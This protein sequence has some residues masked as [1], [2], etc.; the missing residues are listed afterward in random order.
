MVRDW[1]KDICKHTI[2]SSA[3]LLAIAGS[4]RAQEVRQAPAPN[5]SVDL[6]ARIEA[7][8]REID[9]LKRM[10]Q[11]GGVQRTASGAIA[12]DKMD[13]SAVKKIIDGYL[14]EKEQKKKADEA[15]AAK[16]LEDEGF[17]V[18]SDLKMSARW[19]PYQ[20]LILETPNKDFT[21][22]VGGRMQWD[23]VAFTQSRQLL[24]PAQFGDLFD[25]TFFRRVRIQ[26]DGQAYEVLEYNLEF[27]L[28]QVQQGLPNLDEFW[29]GIKDMPWI[30]TIRAGHIK[31]PQGFEGDNVSSSKAM[32]FLERASYSDAFYLNFVTGVWAGNH[33]LDDHAT[34]ALA[35]YRQDN[36]THGN[37]GVDFGDGTWGFTGRVT[38]LPVYEYDGRCLVHL[39]L[40]ATWRKAEKPDPGNA[41]EGVE[42]FR[43]RPEMRDAI[44]DF[45]TTLPG[46]TVALPGNT[47]RLVDTGALLADSATVLGSEVFIVRGPFS[48]QAEWALASAN[49]ANV[50]RVNKNL[51]FHGGYLELSYFLTGE[52]RAY[53]RRLGREGTSYLVGP[54]T[55][56]WFLR[57]DGGG[58]TRGIGAWE[59]AARYSYL[60]LNDGPVQGGVDSAIELGVNW[61]LNPNLKAQFIYNDNNRY[62]FGGHLPGTVQGFGTRVQVFF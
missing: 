25:G 57:G 1:L 52:H 10:I 37:N 59:I 61:Y 31:T 46:T 17:K 48:V 34:W 58:I 27:A 12:D 50:G 21:A 39:G 2:W 9:E 30:G 40:S 7:Q 14:T 62:H 56:F 38:A 19:N 3:V 28:E 4:A 22:H 11:S 54:N 24:P 42:R 23:T 60:N 43:A 26:M 49:N 35:A 41:G 20:G 45:G 32:T 55:N 47:A 15:A 36:Q 51:W 5:A 53:D 18:G 13:D 33:I 8:Q 44:G 6:Q 16:K 29:A